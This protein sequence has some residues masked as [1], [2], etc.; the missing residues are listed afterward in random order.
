MVAVLL[1]YL[2]QFSA[3]DDSIAACGAAL[4]ST[5]MC[6]NQGNKFGLAIEYCHCYSKNTL[7]ARAVA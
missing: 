4:H 6:K 2:S 1:L 7:K 3:S 5:D